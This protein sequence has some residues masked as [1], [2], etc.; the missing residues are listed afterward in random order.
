ME[1]LWDAGEFGKPTVKTSIKKTGR[2]V[3]RVDA[4]LTFFLQA[5]PPEGE[6]RTNWLP[7]SKAPFKLF[8]RAYLPGQSLINQSYVP[9]AVQR[10]P[11][12]SSARCQVRPQGSDP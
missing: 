8:L 2:P 3:A 7:I 1:D 11:W 12:F 5:D 10:V 9:P 4:G 6:A